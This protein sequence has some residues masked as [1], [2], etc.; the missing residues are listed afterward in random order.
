[1]FCPMSRELR[2]LPDAGN[3]WHE[4]PVEKVGELL[5]TDLRAGLAAAEVSSR[6][7][8]FGANRLT[9]KKGRSEWMRFLLQFHQPL[10]YILLAAS[11]VTAVL[12]EW[13]DASVI[14]GVVF[15]NAVVGYVQE[16]RAEKAINAL[17]QMVVTEA[18]VRRDGRKQRVPSEELVPGRRGAAGV[19]R[20]GARGSA[21][22]RGAQPAGR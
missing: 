2:H 5:A 20:Q 11:V 22:L 1:M 3:A 7:K 17:A 6:Q 13:V 21:A 19:R 18:T 9:F 15:L 14:F 12:G 16:A 10:L 8:K 4:L